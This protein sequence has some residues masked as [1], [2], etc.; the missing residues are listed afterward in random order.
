MLELLCPKA[1]DS[2]A[3]PLS[4]LS[5]SRI[6]NGAANPSWDSKE[7]ERGRK[8][9][10]SMTLSHDLDFKSTAVWPELEE[11]GSWGEKK[12]DLFQV[13]GGGEQQAGAV[14]WQGKVSDQELLERRLVPEDTSHSKTWCRDM[15]KVFIKEIFISCSWRI[16]TLPFKHLRSERKYTYIH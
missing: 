13:D 11:K 3:H 5:W 6:V 9:Q 12:T 8:A 15:H 14:V 7:D 2:I 10:R 16:C 1:L 4:L